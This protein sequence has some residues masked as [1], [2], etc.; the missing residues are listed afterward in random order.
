M[1][2]ETRLGESF[3]LETSTV[4]V[5]ETSSPVWVEHIRYEGEAVVEFRFGCYSA[6]MNL[7]VIQ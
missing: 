4:E 5:E 7:R 2:Y 6:H 1:R 3:D